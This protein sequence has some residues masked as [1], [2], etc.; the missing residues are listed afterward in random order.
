MF[1]ASSHPLGRPRIPLLLLGGLLLLS[2]CPAVAE[3]GELVQEPDTIQEVAADTVGVSQDPTVDTLPIPET[4][5]TSRAELDEEIRAD[6]QATFDRVTAFRGIEVTVEA[7]IVRMEGTVPLPTTRARADSLA[8]RLDGVI[9]V[10]DLLQVD[11]SLQ[12]RWAATWV[13]MREWGLDALGYVPLLL[14]G[15]A[16]LAVTVLVERLFGGWLESRV[17]GT[18]NPYLRSLLRRGMR[19][20]ILAAGMLLALNLVGA[21]WIFGAILGTAGIV[22]LAIGFGFKDIIENYL[23]GVLLSFRHPFSPNDQ[24]SMAGHEG[25]VVRL[26]SRETILMTLDGNHVRI[27]NALVFGSVIVNF[28]RNPLRRLSFEVGVGADEELAA[29]QDLGREVLEGMKSLL[30]DPPPAV[31]VQTLGDARVVLRFFAWVDQRKTDPDRA[32]SEAQR[33]VKAALEKARISHP[34][35]EFRL[36]WGTGEDGAPIPLP[37]SP[38]PSAPVG[39]AAPERPAEPDHTLDRQIQQERE[40]EDTDLLTPDPVPRE[41]GSPPE[42]DAARQRPP[43]R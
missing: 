22:G 31:L 24:V 2:P 33:L 7:G 28:T 26:T 38:R 32:R 40:L 10:E 17:R 19:L 6:L 41:R 25:K 9:L 11:R 30:A 36:V 21:T 29:I 39:D 20:L 3:G 34:S 42:A 23:A 1:A 35:P 37:S 27:P 43:V 5:P 15:L 12:R 16:I 18:D 8:R 4:I 14:A 13:Q